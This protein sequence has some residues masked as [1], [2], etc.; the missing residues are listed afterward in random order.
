M[1]DEDF[2]AAV[3]ADN[4]AAPVEEPKAE[5]ETPAEPEAQPEQPKDEQPRDDKGK[6]A[7]KAEPEP[8]PE[9][10]PAAEPVAP[11]PQHAPITALLDEREKRQAA[12]RE[13]QAI[14]QQIAQS[15]QQADVPDPDMD[16]VGYAQFQEGRIQQVLLN[17]TLNT[18][19]RFARKEHGADTVEA[20]KAWSL[21]RFA[22][23]PFYQQQVLNDPDPYEKVVTDYKRDQLFSK[24]SDPSDFDAFLAWKAAQGQLQQQ[25]AAPAASP[26]PAPAIPPRSLASAPSAG[27]MLTEPEQTDEEMFAEAFGK[28]A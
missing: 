22:A 16:P 8:A 23:D 1:E 28:K 27:T 20:A 19:E 2:L 17:Q 24:V 13:L 7:P 4:T 15:Q 3:E 11:E 26:N 9:P 5:P 14:R 10:E 12:E 25:Q 6:F 18:S 21:Q